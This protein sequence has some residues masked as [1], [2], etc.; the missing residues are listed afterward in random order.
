MVTP[1]AHPP[2]E[3]ICGAIQPPRTKTDTET[4]RAPPPPGQIT[5]AIQPPHTK[6]VTATP[7]AHHPLGRPTTLATRPP[8][9]RTATA[10]PREHQPRDKATTGATQP[11]RTKTDTAIRRAPPPRDKQTIGATQP[12]HTKAGIT[13]TAFGLGNEHYIKHNYENHQTPHFHHFGLHRISVCSGATFRSSKKAAGI[14][15]NQAETTSQLHHN[16]IRIL[17]FGH[18]GIH[19]KV[20]NNLVERLHAKSVLKKA[21]SDMLLP[22][23]MQF[24]S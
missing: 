2:P 12:P 10:I 14:K 18:N 19:I 4:Q 21:F 24:N 22:I 1:P 11:P 7:W 16:F 3:R 9:T 17:V 20:N 8:H 15:S 13:T 6:T 23:E 5:S